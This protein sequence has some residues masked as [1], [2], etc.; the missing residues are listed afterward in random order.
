MSDTHSIEVTLEKRL[1]SFNK[2]E[3][4]QK[5]TANDAFDL[6]LDYDKA[7]GV[8]YGFKAKGVKSASFQRYHEV[9]VS[10]S[11]ELLSYSPR[12]NEFT[13]YADWIKEYRSIW[14]R[15]IELFLF[16][17]LLFVVSCL[18]GW[19]IGV[20]Q[21][22]Y[23]PL[24]IEQEFMEMII[25]HDS[26][27]A[28]LQDNPLSGGLEIAFNNIN[29]SIKAFILGALLGVG[30]LVLL[31][32]NGIHF[33]VVFG[34]CMY[35]GFHRELLDFVLS[36]GFLEL[37]I[38][39]ASVFSGLVLGR[40][41]YLRPYS[42]FAERFRFAAREAG[43]LALGIIPWLALAAVFEGFVSPFHYLSMEL[44]MLVGMLLCL[45]F[46]LWTFMPLR[47]ESVKQS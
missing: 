37:T 14:R 17:L 40:V 4:R 21:P 35:R 27:F 34:Y 33:G 28:R 15:H 6:I 22:F 7:V 11:H 31:C 23:V 2:D 32:F 10:V 25:D 8:Y 43:I 19:L 38:I 39:I 18:V 44:K 16:C 42:K 13:G 30:G 1:K 9:I 41:F 29:V 45:A 20:S 26:W 12:L 47:K 5:P 36:H 3:A 24:I 46:I